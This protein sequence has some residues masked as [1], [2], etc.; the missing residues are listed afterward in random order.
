MPETKKKIITEVDRHKGEEIADIRKKTGMSQD[1]FADSYKIGRHQLRS[2]ERGASHPT[3]PSREYLHMI[4]MSPKVVLDM[5]TRP[6][7]V[8]NL[9]VDGVARRYHEANLDWV[10]L[11][12]LTGRDIPNR[13][14]LDRKIAGH[15]A[16]SG[17]RIAGRDLKFLRERLDLN[18]EMALG[19]GAARIE[20]IESDPRGTLTLANDIAL[21]AAVLDLLGDED[22]RCVV[23]LSRGRTV[24]DERNIVM[25]VHIEGSWLELPSKGPAEP[26]V[27][28]P[29]Q[30][31]GAR[32]T[33][34][35]G[36][37]D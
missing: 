27:A 4:E 20:K 35:A 21:R 3:G 34:S 33:R 1:E 28:S 6:D 25:F 30:A 24:D 37:D 36:Y 8:R 15:I 18:V 19:L 31:A 32:D 22:A 17:Y 5:I 2:W 10:S 12:G 7:P 14:E 13:N 29:S 26:V 11:G 23:R 16:K 9:I